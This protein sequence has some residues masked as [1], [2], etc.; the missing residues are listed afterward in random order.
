ML[1][2]NTRITTLFYLLTTTCMSEIEELKQLIITLNSKFD[3]QKAIISDI[4]KRVEF[5]EISVEAIDKKVDKLMKWTLADQDGFKF[6]PKE[7]V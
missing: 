1:Q 6:G 2:Y 5:I 7:K 3:A 4:G